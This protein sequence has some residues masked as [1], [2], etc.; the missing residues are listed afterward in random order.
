MEKRLETVPDD[1][2]LVPPFS[3]T[4]LSGLQAAVKDAS[5]SVGRYADSSR[6]DNLSCQQGKG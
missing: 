1:P 2:A 5:G 6:R 3:D 4:S